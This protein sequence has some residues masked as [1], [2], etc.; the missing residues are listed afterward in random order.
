MVERQNRAKHPLMAVFTPL[1]D[2]VV[3]GFLSAYDLPPLLAAK[4]IAEGT[5]N[6]NYLLVT[7]R[8]PYILTLYEARVNV[9]ELPFFLDLMQHLA[10]KGLVCPQPVAGKDG[11][12]LRE[13][14]GR[15]AAITSFLPGAS[16]KSI[17]PEHCAE[18]GRALAR[19]HLAGADFPRTR[20]NTLSLQGWQILTGMIEA[21]ADEIQAGLAAT[22]RAEI[23]FLSASWPNDLPHG[24]IHA[25]L[26]PDNVF[27]IEGKLSG[28]IDFYFACTDILI[29]DL[30]ICL[31]AWCFEDHVA[32]N[33]TK[34][35]ALLKG[36]QEVRPLSARELE[37]LPILCRG[38]A[39]RFL[40]TRAQN[41]LNR[42][43]GALV[44]P[45]NPLEYLKR[46]SF[47][48]QVETVSAYGLERV[49]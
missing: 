29:Y 16:V 36:Y 41:W 34:A 39:L 49:A 17:K 33:I 38:A 43:E 5:E 26:F 14:A 22:L 24:I 10:A 1:T 45:R 15:K 28:L 2:D 21:R 7:A 4:G 23:D 37:T 44:T 12:A 46:L 6:T 31:N 20:P 25:D 19:L 27:Y 30:A 11:E 40:L 48:Q 32:F 9:E 35:R 47:H 18:L 8:E 13:L 3:R 42:K